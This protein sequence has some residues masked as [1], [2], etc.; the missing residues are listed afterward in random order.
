MKK[1]RQA[2]QP[3]NSLPCDCVIIL[4]KVVFVNAK[5]RE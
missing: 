1:K 2:I 4:Q 3:A 5:V